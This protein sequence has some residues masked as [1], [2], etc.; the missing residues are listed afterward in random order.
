VDL[1][2]HISRLQV[3]DSPNSFLL[4]GSDSKLES[5]SKLHIYIYIMKN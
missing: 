4:S 3:I 1:V 2:L 5:G